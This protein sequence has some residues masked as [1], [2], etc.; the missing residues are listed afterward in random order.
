VPFVSRGKTYEGFAALG[1][2]GT[3]HK[4]QLPSSAAD[5][6]EAVGFRGRLALQVDLRGVIDR[7]HAVVLHDVMR[8]V[9]IVDGE[10]LDV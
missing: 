6:S 1:R 2:I 9:G 7:Y 10:K 4:L 3:A 8:Q 5:L